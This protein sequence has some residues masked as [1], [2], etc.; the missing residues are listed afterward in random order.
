MLL[1]G[2]S[3][4]LAFMFLTS[5][6]GFVV[7]ALSISTS[8]ITDRLALISFK[9]LITSDPSQALASWGNLSIPMCQWHGVA[10]GLRGRRR[11]HVVELGL[12]ELNLVGTITPALGNLTYLRRL[13]LSRNHFHGM[14]PQELGNLPDLETLQLSSN[15]FSGMIPDSLG[16]LSALTFLSIATNNIE[17]SIPPLQG[18]SSIEHLILA[19]NH[20]EGTIPSW[21]GNLTSLQIID[22][23]HNGL[24]GQISESVGNLE[25]LTILSLS[26]NNLSGS[27]PHTLGKLHALTGLYL[28]TNQ[29][30]G[31]LPPSLFN[32]SSLQVLNIQQN[33]FTGGFPSNTGNKLSKLT[34]FLVSDNQ[35]HGV[36]PSSLCNAS[37]LQMIQTVKNFLRGTIPQCLGAQQKNLSVVRIVGNQFEATN[38]AD[39]GFLTS[40]T[41]CSNMLEL[42][43]SYN[44]LQGVLPN[45]I[46]NLSTRLEYLA[47]GNNN[48]TGAIPEGIGNLINLNYLSMG[49]NIFK[50]AIPLS[51]GNLKKL[52][53]LYLLNNALS[54]PIPVTLGNL[55][56]LTRLRLSTNMISEVI[57]SSLSNCP[58]EAIDL[59]HNNLSGL[60]PR[61]LLSMSTLSAT[62][63]LSHNSLS[64]TL[65][66]ELGNLKNLGDLD[67]S[68]N[69]ISGEIPASIGECRSLEYLNTSGN[70]LQGSIPLSLG[71]LRG[72]LVLDL[73]YNNL[74]GTIPEILSSL[75]GLSS[76]NLSFNKFQGAVPQDGVFL[77]ATATLI[78]GNDGLCGGNPQL[79]LPPCSNHSTKKPLQKLAIIVAICSGCVSVALVFALSSLYRKNKKIKANPQSSVIGEQHMRVSY[80]ELAHATNG[81]SSENLIGAGSFGSVYKGRMRGNEQ[82]ALVAVKVINLMQRGASQ[83]FI[84]E[85]KTLR[86]ARHRNL[87]KILTVCS[88]TDF[89]GRDFMAIVYEF[90]PNGNL[91]Q[92]LHQH[93]TED[94]EQKALD[95]IE[96]LH[97]AIDVASSLDYLHQHKPTPIIHCDLKPS[98]VLLDTDMVAH[99]GDFGLARFLYQDME[100]SS[101]W[102]SMRGSIGYAA[103]EYGLGN[104][105]STQGDVYSYGILLLEMFT[106]KRPT[107][108]DF[109]EAIGLRSYVQMSLPHSTAIIIDHQL[110]TEMEGGEASNF[111]SSIISEMIMACITSVLQVGIR[112]SEETPTDR[113]PIGDALRE[114]QAVRDK[115]HS[116]R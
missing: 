96:R 65:P 42:G 41:N 110:L 23:Q 56:K 64:G 76:L 48:L 85:C 51:F 68:N 7:P 66:S 93:I 80:A 28:M 77:N 86:C 92:Q 112:C 98:N 71:N 4:L 57:P 59:S 46:G 54:G 1:L 39:W 8:S 73:S 63:D 37:M 18:L 107:D 22:L 10:C 14:L 88:S 6:A 95:L 81:F 74:S 55:T 62:M 5:S 24:V 34:K 72:L 108:N 61:E 12:E 32:L 52:D 67:F 89:Q 3:F 94:G 113:P 21:L 58:L 25:L 38:D 35:F 100:K 19:R 82:H 91:D 114:L 43:L 115:L 29:I 45:S 11:G 15:Q 9:S 109:G 105:V 79:K 111:N 101:G 97:I 13:H 27:M 78:A 106:G 69:R 50:G 20:L 116:H 90:L 31:S 103:P 49:N 83:S 30:G 16:N 40:L 47:I 104:E 17:G 87:V 2:E 44:K 36:L 70:L 26:E 60:L 84:A 75:P 53:R 33:N 102:A 99:V